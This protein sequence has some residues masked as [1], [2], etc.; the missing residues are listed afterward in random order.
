MVYI[1][2]EPC[3]GLHPRDV[4]SV[5]DATK[6]L[7]ERDNTVLAIEHDERFI[8][9]ADWEIRLGPL[10]GPKGGN[11]IRDGTP[12][13]MARE[14]LSFKRPRAAADSIRVEGLTSHNIVDEDVVLPLGAITAITGV[15]GSGKSSL[16]RALF[17][18]IGDGVSDELITGA[19]VGN[20]HIVD[21]RPIGKTPR[22]TVASYLGVMDGIRQM[23][24]NSERAHELGLGPSAFSLNMPGGRCET[25]QGTGLEK[26]SYRYLPDTFIECPEC[27]GRRFSEE[28]LSV[29][30]L[31]MNITD[32][33]DAPI[34][35]LTDALSDLGQVREMLVCVN[36]LGLGYLT[37]GQTSMSLSG[38]EAQRIKLARALGKKRSGKG[39]YF[40]DEPTAGLERAD[41]RPLAE[42]LLALADGRETVVLT[43]H[44]PVFIAN[45]ADYVIDL[46]VDAGPDGGHI[47]CVGSPEEVFSNP[48]SSWSYLMR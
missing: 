1:L 19:K 36:R 44:D 12:P 39:I 42:A 21:Q 24:A 2:D 5:I 40:L 25:C 30:V 3:R 28:A 37:I 13:D 27:H 45:T 38:G 6:L 7:V 15:S 34:S 17:E 33:L 16:M 35:E 9:R 47:V 46:G 14:A 29:R 10:G 4:E 48:S 20:A 23:F 11:V 26:I 22:S 8:S 18:R 43:E 32:I 31:G 41:T